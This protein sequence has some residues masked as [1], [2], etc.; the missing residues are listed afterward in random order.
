MLFAPPMLLH[1]VAQ[2]GWT[3]WTIHWSTVI[4]L[5]VLGAL[6]HWRASRTTPAPSGGRRL[7]FFAALFVVFVSLKTDGDL[8]LRARR[9]AGHADPL[10]AGDF[11]RADHDAG[12]G[13]H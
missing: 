5:A 13:A 2:V 4:G 10:P 11:G 8:R 3:S 1:P 6:Y 9:L 7:A 12:A